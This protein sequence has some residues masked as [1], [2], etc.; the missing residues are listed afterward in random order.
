MDI[1]W[2]HYFVYYS[3]LIFGR[4]LRKLGSMRRHLFLKQYLL[5][6]GGIII[7]KAPTN[8]KQI[9]YPMEQICGDT[10]NTVGGHS[11]K[12]KVF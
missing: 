12:W 10:V 11:S 4:I 9:C 6:P 5:V 8:V 7:P 3:T 2:F 1:F